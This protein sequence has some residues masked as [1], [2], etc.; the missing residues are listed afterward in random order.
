M[1]V[2]GLSEN[3]NIIQDLVIPGLDT[4]LDVIQSLD[5]E[6]NDVGGLTAAELKGKFDQSGNA[7]KNY[8]NNTLLPAISDTVAEEAVR[9]EA[10]TTRQTQE[11]ARQTA[12]S[13]RASAEQS[14][15]SA[16]GVRQAQESARGT[17]EQA[18]ASAETA[19]EQAEA[20]RVSAEQARMS[21]ESARVLAETAR[22]SSMQQ[23]E[24]A[25]ESAEQ[26]R[27]TAEQGRVSAEAARNVWENYSNS[28]RYVPGNKVAYGGS[29]Y[30][31]TAPTAGNAPADTA[32]WTLIAAKGQDGQGVGDMLSATYDPA[33][34]AQDVFAYADAAEAAAKAAS[35]PSTWM[36]S[37]SE[38]GAAPSSH[39]HP[40]SDLTTAVPVTKGGTGAST[41]EGARSNLGACANALEPSTAA[42]LGLTG[43]ATVNDGLAKL[44]LGPFEIGDTLSTLRTDLGDKWLLCNGAEVDK[45]TYP[46]LYDLSSVNKSDATVRSFGDPY[47]IASDETTYVMCGYDRSALKALIGYTV[48]PTENSSAWTYVN[49]GGIANWKATRIM[50]RNGVWVAVGYSMNDE[51]YLPVIATTTNPAGDWTVQTISSQKCQLTG[52]VYAFGKWITAGS[53]GNGSNTRIFTTANPMSSWAETVIDTKNDNFKL[54]DLAFNGATL[55]AIGYGYYN[56]NPYA[57]VK[58]SSSGPWVLKKLSDTLYFHLNS[59]TYADGKWVAAGQYTSYNEI[60][61]YVSLDLNTWQFKEYGSVAYYGAFIEYWNG[62]WCVGGS[63]QKGYPYM[64]TTTDPLKDWEEITLTDYDDD[65]L[66]ASAAG[67][68]LFALGRD[69]SDSSARLITLLKK[70]PQISVNGVYTYIKAKE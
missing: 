4:D 56:N 37:A 34:R 44:A 13:G 50:V 47:D 67:N 63:Y 64:I 68:Y 41:A 46:S 62:S 45:T 35:R 51:S 18:R 8:I 28:K 29:S 65:V 25:L 11:T 70:L 58:D 39:T 61:I 54:E 36:P 69:H 5:D 12:E 55:C 66:G 22:E 19:R 21:A 15:V 52:L 31:C 20:A 33:G 24:S 26:G 6:P 14:R 1:S 30:V 53:T 23:V 60:G 3:L 17:A 42:A 59:I 7:I 32:Y 2:E 38:V 16:E 10:E 48:N 40:A 9:A 49:L 57:L 43:D 27:V